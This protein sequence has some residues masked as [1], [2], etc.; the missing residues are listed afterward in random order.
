MNDKR[1][2]AEERIRRIMERD[3]EREDRW[4][5]AWTL[6]FIGAA[7]WMLYKFAVFLWG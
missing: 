5:F 7:L 1:R 3:R 4:E 2:E 6:F